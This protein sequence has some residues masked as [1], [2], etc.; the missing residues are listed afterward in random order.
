[1]TMTLV[2][3]ILAILH[4]VAN[5]QS[6][7]VMTMMLVL[8]IGVAVRQD[9]KQIKLTVMTVIHVPLILAMPL[10]DANMYL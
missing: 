9:V 5:P 6:L 1:M 8:T 3:P 4:A 2:L 7:P 10:R